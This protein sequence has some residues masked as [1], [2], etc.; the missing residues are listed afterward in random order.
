MS[1]IAAWWKLRPSLHRQLRACVAR[2]PTS[3]NNGSI[4]GDNI[5]EDQVVSILQDRLCHHPYG[6]CMMKMGGYVARHLIPSQYYPI[7]EP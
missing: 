1:L 7:G 2:L 4:D 3:A 5:S 6:D